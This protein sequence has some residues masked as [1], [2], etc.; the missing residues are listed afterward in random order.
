MNQLYSLTGV[1][2]HPVQANLD[3]RPDREGEGPGN[4]IKFT[5]HSFMFSFS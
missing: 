4:K 5:N 2:L 3:L 1:V